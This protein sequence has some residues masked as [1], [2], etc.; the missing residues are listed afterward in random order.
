MK[1]RKI[2]NK[3]FKN[4]E[5]QNDTYGIL[6]VSS[7]SCSRAKH[8]HHKQERRSHCF[9]QSS[10]II[11]ESDKHREAITLVNQFQCSCMPKDSCAVNENC[12]GHNKMHQENI[13]D[14]KRWP[15]Q[16]QTQER[17]KKTTITI[18]KDPLFM[19]NW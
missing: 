10:E 3:R 4:Q 16:Y 13:T 15:L 2:Q 8:P 19:D 18:S 14:A 1:A 7:L 9:P 5:N 6:W 17:C 12:I 11:A